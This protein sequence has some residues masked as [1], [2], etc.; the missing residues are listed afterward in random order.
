MGIA[1]GELSAAL[2]VFR[3]EVRNALIAPGVTVIIDQDFIGDLVEG[4]STDIERD[5]D[6]WRFA[7]VAGGLHG[8][9]FLV[10]LS[11]DHSI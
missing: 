1:S 5:D 7:T 6:E 10:C 11:E 2:V 3:S 9:W 4:F 8:F